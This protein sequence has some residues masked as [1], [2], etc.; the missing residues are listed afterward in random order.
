[1]IWSLQWNRVGHVTHGLGG[2]AELYRL[3]SAIHE[4]RMLA[5]FATPVAEYNGLHQQRKQFV[6]MA[7]LYIM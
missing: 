6:Q 5:T 4:G 3:L 1:M 7:R 2:N